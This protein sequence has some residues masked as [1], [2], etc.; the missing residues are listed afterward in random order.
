MFMS[1]VVGSNRVY[2]VAG[3]ERRGGVG[4]RDGNGQGKGGGTS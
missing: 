3:K 2:V 4:M 1:W